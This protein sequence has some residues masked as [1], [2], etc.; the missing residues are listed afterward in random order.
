MSEVPAGASFAVPAWG[1]WQLQ[2]GE[3]WREVLDPGPRNATGTGGKQTWFCGCCGRARGKQALWPACFCASVLE[4]P[5]K[6]W[7]ALLREAVPDRYRCHRGCCD[8]GKRDCVVSCC[9]GMGKSCLRV[10]R[11]CSS[12]AGSVPLRWLPCGSACSASPLQPSC[13]GTFWDWGLHHPSSGS[14][15]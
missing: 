13:S 15:C 8:H 3:V 12:W 6:N 10:A 9:C 1:G 14:G 11:P 7:R 2:R 5:Q 4:L